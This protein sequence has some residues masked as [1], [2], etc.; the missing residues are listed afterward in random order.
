MCSH[1]LVH[2][3]SRHTTHGGR[4]F[5]KIILFEFICISCK[6]IRE[7]SSAPGKCTIHENSNKGIKEAIKLDLTSNFYF[8]FSILATMGSILN[9]VVLGTLWIRRKKLT[10]V[11]I[12]IANIS[13]A[14]LIPSLISLPMYASSSFAGK[15]L[16]GEMGKYFSQ[17]S[18]RTR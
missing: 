5:L 10:P 4:Y 3:F 8:L 7:K 1:L 14:G 16:Y 15:W 6:A 2:L 17:Q 18:I 12:C 13:V 11:E 9:M